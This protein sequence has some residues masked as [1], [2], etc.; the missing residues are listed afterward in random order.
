MSERGALGGWTIRACGD[1]RSGG[2]LEPVRT[3]WLL[4]LA[5]VV[6]LAVPSGLVAAPVD[7]SI[8]RS[9]ITVK[10]GSST[11]QKVIA[12]RLGR[13][14]YAN[15]YVDKPF[16][17]GLALK[18]EWLDPQGNLRARWKDK[19]QSGD[20]KGTRLFAFITAAIYHGLT[21]RWT[22]RLTVGS[23]VKSQHRFMLQ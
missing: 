13:R 4:P 10:N 2:T 12:A 5:L 16:K 6:A 19:T 18:I 23:V 3:K 22:V 8:S 1:D 7:G 20:R 9:T 15:F 17:S 11:P 14:I 21:G